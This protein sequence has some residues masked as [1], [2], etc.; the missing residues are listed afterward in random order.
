MNSLYAMLLSFVL[1]AGLG[2]LVFLLYGTMDI[3]LLGGLI[4]LISAAL[5]ALSL[6][7][8]KKTSGKAVYEL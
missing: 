3:L 6:L 1:V 2:A 7:A 4:A 5:C 8:L